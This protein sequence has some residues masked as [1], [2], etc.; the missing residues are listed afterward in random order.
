MIFFKANCKADKRKP[1]IG[2]NQ[3]QPTLM[4]ISKMAKNKSE[5]SDV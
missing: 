3:E 1:E 4:M 5:V 2:Q